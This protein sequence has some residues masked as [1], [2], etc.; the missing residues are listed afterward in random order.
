MTVAKA[1]IV[2]IGLLTVIDCSTATTQ[3][4]APNDRVIAKTD[5]GVIRSA[6]GGARGTTVVSAPQPAVLSALGAAYADL[7]IEVKLWDPPHGEVGNR[8][9]TKMYRLAG[10][11]LSEY[12]SC[13]ITL[14]GAA[15]DSYRVTFSVVSQVTRVREG[16]RIETALTAYAE[17]IGSSKGTISCQTLGTLEAKVNEAAIRHM[18]S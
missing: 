8:N 13:G 18:S 14:M 2:V 7:G 3:R 11:P 6:D 4:S 15:A 9:F 16:S 17:D 12:V 1:M 10:S 5:V